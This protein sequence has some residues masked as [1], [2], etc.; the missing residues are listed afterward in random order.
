M[1]DEKP[2][3]EDEYFIKKRELGELFDSASDLQINLLRGDNPHNNH[4]IFY[5][6]L[7]HAGWVKCR[8]A[9]SAANPIFHLWAK[10]F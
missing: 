9:V 1:H 5:P 3:K 10:K 7:N 8:L 4:P 6:I 2:E